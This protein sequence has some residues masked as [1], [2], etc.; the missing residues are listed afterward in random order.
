M[1]VYSII[2]G[3]SLLAPIFWRRIKQE[4]LPSPLRIGI[5]GT[6]WLFA[7][8]LYLL[9]IMFTS[10]P[11]NMAISAT[12]T[13]FSFLFAMLILGYSFRK[14]SALGVLVIMA[15]IT[16]SAFFKATIVEEGESGSKIDETIGG[17]ILSI[18]SAVVCGLFSCLFK[19]WVTIEENSG[20]VFGC[21]G[22]VGILIGIPCIVIAH[23]TGLQAFQIPDWEVSLLILGDSVLCSVICNFFFSRAFVYLTPVIVQ[24]GL[25]MTIPIS[26]IITSLILRTHSYP[27]PGILGACLIF[28][29]VMIVSYDQAK[30]EQSL[31]N[32]QH[33]GKGSDL[34]SSVKA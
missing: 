15:G 26:F 34:E 10:V 30:Y 2:V 22:F 24:V 18:S 5:L 13:V 6:L 17:I 25:T 8:F 14:Y 23:Y 4:S 11:T 27:I 21:F 7:Q 12:S 9:S 28:V 29:A 32:S 1:A 3:L 20:I 16:L 33:L 31:V 19:K